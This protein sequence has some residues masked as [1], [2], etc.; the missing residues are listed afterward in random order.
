M[1]KASSIC[2]CTL[3]LGLL[4]N[5]L[6]AAD[7]T[8]P[9]KAKPSVIPQLSVSDVLQ[10]NADARGGLQHWRA[11]T[12]ISMTGRMEAGGN[13]IRT[14]SPTGKI[15]TRQVPEQVEL[16]FVLQMKRPRK[17]RVEI[18]FKGTTS[19]Q[20]YELESLDTVEDHPAYKLKVTLKGGQVEHVWV[21]AKSFLDLKFEGNPRRL[22]GK[23]HAVQTYFRD[24][25]S[26]NGLM[27]PYTMETAVDGL[28]QTEKITIETVELNSKLADSRFGKP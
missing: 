8:Q 11:V 3:A 20:T 18:Q 5:S 7:V 6:F 12:S 15:I 9:A 19:V 1:S 24:Y 13:N 17:E 16:P 21:D 25:R 2:L 26:V 22:D 14:F 27:I 10:K 23:T 28:K 4:A